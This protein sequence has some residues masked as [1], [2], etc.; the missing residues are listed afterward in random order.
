MK[1]D[2]KISKIEKPNNLFCGDKMLDRY[3]KECK[4][5]YEKT[6]PL[7]VERVS[8]GIIH[9]LRPNKKNRLSSKYGGVTDEEFNLIELSLTK[10][11]SPPNFTV[12]FNDWFKGANPNCSDSDIDGLRPGENPA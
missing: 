9:P 4:T 12:I 6:N 5:D 10:R 11:V 7:K 3:K 1:V 8:N 2:R